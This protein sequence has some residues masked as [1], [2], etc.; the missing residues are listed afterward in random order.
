MFVRRLKGF[1]FA[2]T[3]LYLVAYGLLIRYR[4]G[5]G[6]SNHSGIIGSQVLLGI[7]KV[8]LCSIAL[9]FALMEI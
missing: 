7:G 6:G 4:G 9:L 3:I 8:N 5:D 2:G 1:I